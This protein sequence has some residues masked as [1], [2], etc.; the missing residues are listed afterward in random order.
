M[1]RQSKG[2]ER[3]QDSK[4][5][6]SGSRKRPDHILEAG[7]L[8]GALIWIMSLLS[9]FGSSA[10]V[11]RQAVNESLCG[12]AFRNN[13]LLGGH[14]RRLDRGSA[15][16]SK[17]RRRR[18]GSPHPRSEQGHRERRNSD[19]LRNYEATRPTLH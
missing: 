3:C 16:S 15:G 8:G 12:N 14:C 5:A 4:V 2:K 11:E 17:L 9:I 13:P 6:S 1:R 18:Q 7:C 10:G 19:K